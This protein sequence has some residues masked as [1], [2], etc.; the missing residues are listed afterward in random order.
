MVVQRFVHPVYNSNTYLISFPGIYKA[1][2]IDSGE[3]DS[4]LDYLPKGVFIKGVFITH[5]HFDHILGLNKLKDVFPECQVYVSQQG[6]NG[7]YSEKLNLSFYHEIPF[8]YK[9][10]EILILNEHDIEN[11]IPGFDIEVLET[12]G[13]NHGCLTYKLNNYLF[14][15]DAYI[16]GYNVVT[17]LKGG[18]RI[19]NAA[20]IKKIKDQIVENTIICPGHLDIYHSW[21]LPGLPQ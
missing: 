8:I 17:K 11:L 4:V 15:G 5:S 21:D 2:L 19:A 14:T 6:Q 3:M 16:P 13:H 12:P 18:D 10:D 20:S 7:L 1:W 9:H